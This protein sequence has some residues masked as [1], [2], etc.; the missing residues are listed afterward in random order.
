MTDAADNNA[1]PPETDSAKPAVAT[2]AN[3]VTPDGGAPAAPTATPSAT[4][5]AATAASAD[6]APK[7]E[8]APNSADTII[9]GTPVPTTLPAPDANDGPVVQID[10]A[11]PPP[12]SAPTAAGLEV[13]VFGR[14]DVGMI[15]E[16]NEDNF[17]ISDLSQNLRS[18]K[19]EIRKHLV[20]DAGSL[21]AVCDGM[22]GAAAGE[23]ASQ[24]AVD[25]IYELLQSGSPASSKDH[26][27]RQISEA[28]GEAGA[29]IYLAAKTN[30]A[31]R[32]MGTT[33]TVVG[34][35][36]KTL[37]MG[38][39]GD[40]RAYL[41]R[42]GKIKQLT[43]DQSLVAKLIEAGQLT[44]EEAENYEHG[45][46]ILQALGTSDSVAVDLSFLDL[47]RGDAVLL[48]SDGLS[49]LVTSAQMLEVLMTSDEPMDCCKRLTDLANAAGG[50]DNV[51]VI[52]ARFDGDIPAPGPGDEFFGY[53]PWILSEEPHGDANP[54]VP[55]KIKGA[56][57]PPPGK[58]VK[59]AVSI[60]PPAAA[61]P[62]AVTPSRTPR[63][64]S[65]DDDEI[66]LPVS[67]APRYA[68][69]AFLLALAVGLLLAALY[70]IK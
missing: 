25:T 19:P 48:C 56:D 45:H 1:A 59:N 65:A 2:D 67:N 14:T 22:G 18:V 58:D 49:G 55:S 38:Q 57:A 20:G 12:T 8:V 47:R 44:E 30:R 54:K 5:A 42:G 40:S 63:R 9:G 4:P 16:H 69:V 21:F 15:R 13:R 33:S 41:V 11:E 60:R 39:V 37:F 64:P 36:D 3:A 68:L 51:T 31:Q 35:Y 23:V 46:I 32:G 34:V 27:A 7:T 26:F 6:G 29:R 10:A 62:D 52:V 53:Q 70:L 50:H 43:K 17:L 28:I 66:S 24:M 61:A